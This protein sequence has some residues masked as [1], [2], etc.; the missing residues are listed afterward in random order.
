MHPFLLLKYQT[1]GLF[2]TKPFFFLFVLSTFFVALSSS[3]MAF[4]FILLRFLRQSGWGG[5]GGFAD[6]SM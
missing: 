2:I 4:S 1:T 6:Q 5:G 3:R